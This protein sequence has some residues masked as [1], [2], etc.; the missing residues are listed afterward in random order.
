MACFGLL[1]KI[2]GTVYFKR[3]FAVLESC[4][5]DSEDTLH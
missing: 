2:R 1:K 4:I 3:D 5:E